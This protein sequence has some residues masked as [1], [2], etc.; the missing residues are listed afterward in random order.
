M[1]FTA[2]GP[3][4]GA[5]VERISPNLD[6]EK[7]QA[8]VGGHSEDSINNL[9]ANT[10]E[11]DIDGEKVQEFQRGVE[12]VRIITTIWNKPTLISMFVL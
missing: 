2:G 1:S 6:A 9:D 8:T 10:N 11:Y 4:P 5:N 7:S 3:A 12:R